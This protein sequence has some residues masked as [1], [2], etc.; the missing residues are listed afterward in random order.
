MPI[1]RD[2]TKASRPVEATDGSDWNFRMLIADHY[3]RL[4]TMR[5]WCKI[6]AIVQILY[7]MIRTGWKFVPT[8]VKG[9]H[10]FKS[11]N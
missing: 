9:K 10:A 7:I 11:L 6:A 3:K 4:V 5:R 8:L 2:L 1:S